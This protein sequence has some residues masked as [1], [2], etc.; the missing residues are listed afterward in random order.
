MLP[1]QALQTLPLQLMEEL[2]QQTFMPFEQPLRAV[3]WINSLSAR[4]AL[5]L[6]ELVGLPVTSAAAAMSSSRVLQRL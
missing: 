6:V 3:R 2:P 4:L 5:T 1:Q